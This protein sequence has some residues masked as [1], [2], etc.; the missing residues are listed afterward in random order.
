MTIKKAFFWAITLLLWGVLFLPAQTAQDREAAKR[1][2]FVILDVSGSM[3]ERAKFANVKEYLEKDVFGTLLKVGDSFTLITFGNSAEEILSRSVSSEEVKRELLARVRAL[4]ADDNYTDIGTAMEKLSE[5]LS[6]R[7]STDAR[8]VILFITDGKN[9]PPRSSPYHGKDLSLDERFR[10]VGEKISKSGWFLYVIGI[11]TETDARKIADSVSGSVYHRTDESLSGVAVEEYVAK[12]DDA[13]K[14]REEAARIA[15][16]KAAALE[17]AREEERL[18]DSEGP[19]QSFMRKLAAAL[20][21]SLSVIRW[22]LVGLI[23]MVLLVLAW[24]LYRA[25]R[26]VQVVISD[27]LMGKADTLHRRLAPWSGFMLNSNQGVLPGIGD[28]NRGV[29]RLER[30]LFGLRV[31]VVDDDA[32]AEN[33]PYKKKGLHSLSKNIIELAN[34]NRVRIGIIR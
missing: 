3:N 19:L 16:E 10:S 34:G 27:N 13:A 24:F 14:V 28:E 15:A 23:V 17:A 22:I 5:V 7:G 25:L 29:F 33:S 32:I 9:T 31:R 6:S 11:G 21:I 12:V 2:V 8:Q 20:G 18:R 26:P 30:G 1:D 4:G